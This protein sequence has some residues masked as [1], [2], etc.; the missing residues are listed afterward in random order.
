MQSTIYTP[1]CLDFHLFSMLYTYPLGGVQASTVKDQFCPWDQ[2]V[3]LWLW[4][5]HQFKYTV[6]STCIPG[7][8]LFIAGGVGLELRLATAFFGLVLMLAPAEVKGKENGQR[9]LKMIQKKMT[10]L[11]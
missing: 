3:K 7:L 4:L 5:Q 2:I 8:A 6:V 10:Y 11:H 1:L 9:R